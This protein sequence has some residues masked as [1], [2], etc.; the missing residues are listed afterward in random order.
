MVAIREPIRIASSRSW[1]MKMVV[2]FIVR[3]SAGNSSRSPRWMRGSRAEKGSSISRLSRSSAIA[4]H[5]GFG[6]IG[7]WGRTIGRQG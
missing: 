3:E 6:H 7:S 1:V 5:A 2:V 4:L